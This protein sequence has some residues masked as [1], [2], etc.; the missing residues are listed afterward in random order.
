MGM[1]TNAL[2]YL[3]FNIPTI[4]IILNLFYVFSYANTNDIIIDNKTS[5]SCVDVFGSS[6]VHVFGCEG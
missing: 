6:Y 3:L 4:Q 2:Q 5:S 1:E